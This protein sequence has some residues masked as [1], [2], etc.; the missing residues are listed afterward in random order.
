MGEPYQGR[1]GLR[2]QKKIADGGASGHVQAIGWAW[3]MHCKISEQTL[4]MTNN[5]YF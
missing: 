4:N 3:G 2:S 5:I 1:S